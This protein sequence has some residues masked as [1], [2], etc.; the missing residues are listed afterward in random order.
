MTNAVE[1]AFRKGLESLPAKHEEFFDRLWTGG[2]L[3]YTGQNAAE[4]DCLDEQN[5]ALA[6]STLAHDERLLVVLPDDLPQRACAILGSAIIWASLRATESGH[7]AGNVLYFGTTVG[8]RK[9]L[10]QMSIGSTPLTDLF[11]QMTGRG[12][13]KAVGPQNG[14]LPRLYTVYTP[15]DP[16]ALVR[17]IQPAWLAIDC[18]DAT[19]LPWLEQLL[20]YAGDMGLPF[21][22]WSHNPLSAVRSHF[23]KARAYS[24]QWPWHSRFLPMCNSGRMEISGLAKA[25]AEP[26]VA[27]PLQPCVAT[28][29]EFDS[30][31][32]HLAEAY[33]NM[34][35]SCR[36]NTRSRLEVD[37]IR[38]AFRYFRGLERLPIP[39]RIYEDEC[40]RYWGLHRIVTLKNSAWGFVRECAGS[41]ISDGIESAL[42][43]M[44]ACAEW[45]QSHTPPSWE[46]LTEMILEGEASEGI[47]LIVFPGTGHAS[48][49]THAV[50]AELNTSKDDLREMNTVVMPMREAVNALEARLRPQ[51]Q[52]L[53][54][55]TCDVDID[56]SCHVILS[57]LPYGPNRRR[58]APLVEADDIQ[59]IVLPHQMAALERFVCDVNFDLVPEKGFAAKTVLAIAGTSITEDIPE[60]DEVVLSQ[61]PP[62]AIA[63]RPTPQAASSHYDELWKPGPAADELSR[64]FEAEEAVDDA[65]S[66]ASE[67]EVPTPGG[68]GECALTIDTAVEVSFTD[69]WTGLFAPSARLN[70]VRTDGTVSERYVRSARVGDRVLYILG[71]ARQSLY[72]LIVSRVHGHPS[73]R[74]LL[75]FVLRWQQEARER[76][77]AWERD[78][79]T[80][81]DLHAQIVAHGSSLQTTAGLRCWVNGTVLRPRDPKDLERLAGLLRMPFTAQHFR[82]V[83]RAGARIHGLHIQLSR[84]L[85]RWLTND[86]T[87]LALSDDVLDDETGLTFGDLQQ[88]LMV[89]EVVSCVEVCGAF[90]AQTLGRIEKRSTR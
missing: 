3:R 88:A 13:V 25:L 59:V 14:F 1:E 46:L 2:R 9:H 41:G 84:R 38:A 65:V 21:I 36:G 90:D 37:T 70:F 28:G 42:A 11:V 15:F 16:V 56:R 89:L 22:A 49:F 39:L 69:D 77:A 12:T 62:R 8:I 87:S 67:V 79:R 50:L 34:T 18:G 81:D 86:D 83:H 33:R 72:D 57:T 10:T 71:Q 47:R 32:K 31:L 26:C 61:L 40:S 43:Q 20:S 55:S 45:L 27:R 68:Y 53:S 60:Q 23:E 54:H 74:V 73:M 29:A 4:F 5:A 58:C 78:G 7:P 44:D 85:S 48:L 64:I 63:G 52:Y 76:Y 35:T 66:F 24:V 51:E 82:Q 30:F 75:E 80:L 6:C 17:T 19:D